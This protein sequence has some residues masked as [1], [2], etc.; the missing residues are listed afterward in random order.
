MNFSL[1]LLMMN[2]SLLLLMM[3]FSLLLL[4]MMNFS[5]MLSMTVVSLMMICQRDGS[6]QGASS[7]SR[8]N[9]ILIISV[10]ILIIQRNQRLQIVHNKLLFLCLFLLQVV[11]QYL[12]ILEWE[13]IGHDGKCIRGCSDRVALAQSCCY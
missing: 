7:R 1:L 5:V 10:L 9:N 4:L 2:F 11:C 6:Y 3:N 8:L 13:N 12:Q